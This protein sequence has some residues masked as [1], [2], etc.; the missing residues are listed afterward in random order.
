[1]YDI[2]D[3]RFWAE[4]G[5]ELWNDISPTI[6]SIYLKGVEGGIDGLPRKAQVLADVDAVNAN[7]LAFLEQY[8]LRWL[9]DVLRTSQ[10]QAVKVFEEWIRSPLPLPALE[11]ALEPIFGEARAER[12]AVT[13]TT[14]IFAEG[15]QAAWEDTGLVESSVWMTAQDDLVCPICSDLDGTHV[16]IGDFDASPPAHPECRCYLQPVVSEDALARK[17]DEILGE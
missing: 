10:E 3:P 2:T 17:L 7:A 5:D 1:V 4:A 9:D 8:R 13:E 15:N 16:G 14:R 6:L 11:E 12:I